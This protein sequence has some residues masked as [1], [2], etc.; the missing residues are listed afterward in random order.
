MSEEYERLMISMGH[1]D[2]EQCGEMA[3]ALLGDLSDKSALDMGCGTGMVGASLKK[4][5]IHELLGIDASH[6]MLK[7]A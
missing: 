3:V 7:I 2:P 4:R 6:G 5:G 1:P